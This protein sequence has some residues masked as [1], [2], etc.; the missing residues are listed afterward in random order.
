MTLRDIEEME[1]AEVRRE[2]MTLEQRREEYVNGMFVSLCPPLYRETDVDRLPAAELATVLAWRMNPR[3]LLLV[4]PTGT[5]KTRCVWMLL[6][7]LLGQRPETRIVAFDGLGWGIAVSKAYGDPEYTERWFDKVC[8]C[9]VLFLDDLF[10][11]KMTEAQE[12]AVYGVFER[13]SAQMLPII[14]TMNS[15]GKMILDRMTDQGR[16]DRGEPLLRRMAEF[17][18]VIHFGKQKEATK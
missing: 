9:D 14:V 6:R 5:G 11:A 16:A 17:C 12:Q 2:S 10:K 3:G 15:T 8:Q 13:R 1:R 7:Q 18:D 4:G